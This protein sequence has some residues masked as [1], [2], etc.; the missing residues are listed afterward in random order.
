MFLIKIRGIFA[1]FS[2]N[3][4]DAKRGTTLRVL[5]TVINLKVLKILLILTSFHYTATKISFI[6][7]FSGNR[8]NSVPISTF[9]CLW[10]ITSI[11]SQDRSAYFLQQNKQTDP[12]NILISHRYMSVGTGRQNSVSEITVSFLWIHKWEPDIFIVFS[13]ALQMQCRVTS[14]VS[15][16]GR[17]MEYM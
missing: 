11:Y 1:I 6:N 17:Q 12:E 16:A 14:I 2:S 3:F 9:M 8:V 15:R 7:S 13:P 5:C 10:V 4:L